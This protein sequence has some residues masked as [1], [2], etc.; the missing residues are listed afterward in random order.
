MTS[1]FT[2]LAS[3]G[4]RCGAYYL[5]GI[6]TGAQTVIA[7]FAG[8]ADRSA[9][10]VISMTGVDQTTPVG[11]PA[12]STTTTN[13]PS[14]T[15]GSVGSEDLLCDI[16]HGAG[17]SPISTAGANQTERT[18]EAFL[19]S[20]HAA[21]STQSGA[22]GG[23][24]SWTVDSDFGSLLGAVAFKPVAAGGAANPKGPLSGIMLC[25]PLQRVV[26]F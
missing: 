26:G 11:T 15:V 22:D 2:P 16:V 14:V 4:A 5:A 10:A 12:T 20:V 19:S 3:G 25:G 21:T 7:S 18:Q 24:M 23:V 17:F 13:T 9:L 8:T 6:P 1:L